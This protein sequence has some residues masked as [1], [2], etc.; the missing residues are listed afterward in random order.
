MTESALLENENHFRTIFNAANDGIF[1][2]EIDNGTILDAN[3]KICEMFGVT[4]DEALH[5]TVGDFSSGIAPYTQADAMAWIRKVSLEGP[6]VFEWQAK[7]K[8][9]QLLWLEVNMCRAAVGAV[10]RMVV[11][12]RDIAERKLAEQELN[13]VNEELRTINRIIATSTGVLDT[14]EMLDKILIEALKIV[15]LEGGTVCLVEPDDTLRLVTERDTSAA[16]ILDLTTNDIK[17]GDCLCGNCA[18]DNCPL[19]LTNREEVLAYAT[20]EAQRGEVINFHAAFPFTIKGKSVGVLCV[21]SRTGKKP[22]ER[23]LKL[24]ETLTAQVALAIENAQIYGKLQQSAVELER[25]VDARTQ[26][27]EEELKERL[28]AEESLHAATTELK[29]KNAEL[30]RMNKIF[31]GRELRMMELKERIKELEKNAE[32]RNQSASS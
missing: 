26:E 14:K 6:Q 10:D 19:I 7:D 11:T 16:T 9:G 24:L 27:L 8:T 12:V 20:R 4:L 15:G 18:H 30:E 25:R 29:A 2:Q 32:L 17:I 28:T 21:F 23:S 3:R 22:T 13:I 1:I 31:I 5:A